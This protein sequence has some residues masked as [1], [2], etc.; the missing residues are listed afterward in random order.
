MRS[1]RRVVRRRLLKQWSEPLQAVLGPRFRAQLLEQDI[2]GGSSICYNFAK[3][4]DCSPEAKVSAQSR[5]LV[6]LN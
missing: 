2:L 6:H 3:V 1:F 4:D 5:G